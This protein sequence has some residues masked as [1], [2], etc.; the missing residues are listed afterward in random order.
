MPKQIR[1]VKYKG[2]MFTIRELSQ[3]TGLAVDVLNVRYRKGM[4]GD[5]LCK[6]SLA[7]TI[8]IKGHKYTYKEAASHFNVNEST[9]R[10]RYAKGL[11][12]DELIYGL[13]KVRKSHFRGQ[14][15]TLY[16]ISHITGIPLST[17]S[18]RYKK[19]KRGADLVAVS[20]RRKTPFSFN[21][22]GQVLT[23]NEICKKYHLD[24][25]LVNKRI[26]N[27]KRGR[28]LVQS[29]RDNR[30]VNI[31]GINYTV[32]DL[33]FVSGINA[34]TI[35]NRIRDGKRGR[36]VIAPINNN[37]KETTILFKGKPTTYNDLSKKY[38]ISSEL[39]NHRYLRGFRDD[40][41][42]APKRPYQI[43]FMHK[44]Q[45]M[46]F[47]KLSEQTGLKI[48]SLRQRYARGWRDAQLV[49]PMRETR[50]G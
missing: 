34:G 22:D 6:K 10:T 43:T 42:V 13:K 1:V 48:S 17:L 23:I 20:L 14:M 50:N 30:L 49:Q 5:Q 25:A 31:D 29:I 9:I 37:G 38:H 8:V 40:A 12:D 11:R 44:G 47:K 26:T 19:G 24:S 15:R 21:I 16:E 41:L 18:N 28:E 32:E 3:L 35:R 27:H 45:K 36:E 46:T 2:R 39:I 33:T 7:T 4:R